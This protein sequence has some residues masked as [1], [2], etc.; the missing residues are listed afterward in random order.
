M[1][2]VL[3]CSYLFT[4]STILNGK[5][6]KK[7]CHS[8]INEHIVLFVLMLLHKGKTVLDVLLFKNIFIKYIRYKNNNGLF[9]HINLEI[10]KTPRLILTYFKY[11]RIQGS[12]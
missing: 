12:K 8:L 3:Y 1:C 5:K 4:F 9:Y 7:N 11:C 10:P 2:L 6:K